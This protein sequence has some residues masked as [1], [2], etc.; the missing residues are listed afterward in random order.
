MQR[1]L[2]SAALYMTNAKDHG[3]TVISLLSILS[4]GHWEC[5]QLR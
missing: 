4:R 1:Q 5:L 3:L 2:Q